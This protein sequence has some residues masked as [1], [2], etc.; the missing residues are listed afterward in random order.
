M[1]CSKDELRFTQRRMYGGWATSRNGGTFLC[2]DIH[3]FYEL[4]KTGVRAVVLV[5]SEKAHPQANRITIDGR[6]KH[7]GGGEYLQSM[8][9]RLWLEGRYRDRRRYVR[10]EYEVPA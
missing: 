6:V 5:A 2:S 10:V 3:Q 1:R 8:G 7:D 4:P 9:V